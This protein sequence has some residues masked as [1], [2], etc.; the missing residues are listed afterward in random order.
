MRRFAVISLA[1]AGLFFAAFPAGAAKMTA[2]NA[3]AAAAGTDPDQVVCVQ[4][5]APTGSRVGGGLQCHTVKEW[6]DL[7]RNGA[8]QL[9]NVSRSGLGAGT[10]GSG[11][12][13]GGIG[14]PR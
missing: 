8:D 5:Q 2:P 9:N 11:I 1:G 3:A 7:Q 12:P 6:A 4:T 13:A 14:G 10:P